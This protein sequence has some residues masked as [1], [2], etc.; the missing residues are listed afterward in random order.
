MRD[1]VRKSDKKDGDGA[2]LPHQNAATGSYYN[3]NE[4]C[5]LAQ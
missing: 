1:R 3:K 5:N 2:I 4:A